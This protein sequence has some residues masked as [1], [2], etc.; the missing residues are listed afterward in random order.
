MSSQDRSPAGAEYDEK[1]LARLLR[2]VAAD[3][4]KNAFAQVFDHF[5]PRIKAFLRRQGTPEAQLDDLLQEVMIK[6][7]RYAGRF[8]P[9]KG[10]AV[11]WIFTVTRN[12]R[13]DFLRKENRPEPDE[14]D[15]MLVPT[16]AAASDDDVYARESA[17]RI[18]TALDTLPAEQAEMLRLAFFEE[19]SH[20]E[21]AQQVGL[22]LGTV[23]SRIR[24]AF[25][26]LRS[27]LTE[28]EL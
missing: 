20:N 21:I 10:K 5:A 2:L 28:L 25:N 26:R 17:E 11:T 15:P 3:R 1:A 13:I 23:K 27:S 22:P 16:V 18:A 24:L 9:Q 8:D 7:W 6:V 19:K 12:A 14:N 4:D